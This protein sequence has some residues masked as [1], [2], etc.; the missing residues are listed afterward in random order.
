MKNSKT[1]I[2]LFAF[3]TFCLFNLMFA[4]P[5]QADLLD[6]ITNNLDSFNQ[7]ANLPGNENS[8]LPDVLVRIINLVLGLLGLVFVI[9][10]IYGG[11]VYMTAGGKSENTTKAITIIRNSVIGIAIILLSWAIYNFVI[12]NILNA[13]N[14]VV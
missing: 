5:V 10:I 11:F 9:L 14:G 4:L 1:K 8:D 3:L 13:I 2:L 6:N 7:Q 12:I